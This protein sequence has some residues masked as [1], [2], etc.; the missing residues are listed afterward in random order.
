MNNELKKQDIPE[1]EEDI[2]EWRMSRA[3]PDAA[4]ASGKR[5]PGILS[6]LIDEQ[7]IN[8]KRKFPRTS[9]DQLSQTKQLI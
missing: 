9:A 1:V 8:N 5:L 4:R 7:Q 3:L 2:F 6:S